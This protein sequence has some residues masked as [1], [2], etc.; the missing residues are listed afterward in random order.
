M[1][2]LCIGQTSIIWICC[3]YICLTIPVLNSA[4]NQTEVTASLDWHTPTSPL[5]PPALVSPFSFF[6][7]HYYCAV[8]WWGWHCLWCLCLPACHR[9]CWSFLSSGVLLY[10]FSVKPLPPNISKDKPITCFLLYFIQYTV[11]YLFIYVF[12]K[13]QQYWKLNECW[14]GTKE[15]LNQWIFFIW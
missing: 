14:Y 10:C 12:V 7:W 8:L 11:L 1:V 3:V 13:F 4:L 6:S 9:R 2:T 5:H 15:Q